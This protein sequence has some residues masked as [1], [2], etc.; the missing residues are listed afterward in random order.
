[1]KIVTCACFGNA[2]SGLVHEGFGLAQ[3]NIV[4]LA[5]S[6]KVNTGAKETVIGTCGELLAGNKGCRSGGGS[7]GKY[8]K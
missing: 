3:A 5:T 1:L 4:G 7:K 2:N 8:G 6:I